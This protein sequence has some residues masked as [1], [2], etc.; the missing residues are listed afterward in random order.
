[1]L[2][3][4]PGGG[5]LSRAPTLIDAQGADD[6]GKALTLP[7]VEGAEGAREGQLRGADRVGDLREGDRVVVEGGPAEDAREDV[8]RAT[9][10]TLATTLRRS[11]PSS[12][13]K[14]AEKPF[15]KV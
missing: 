3:T 11:L 9:V 1:M 5:Q 15:P 4:V 10:P 12:I 13:A 8:A 7:G 6:V 14:V 2:D